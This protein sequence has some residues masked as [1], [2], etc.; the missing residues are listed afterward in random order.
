M[1]TLDY[2]CYYDFCCKEFNSKYNLKRHINSVHL[3]I[4]EYQCDI[5]AKTLVSKVAFKEHSY[6]H[7]R[8]KPISCPYA[9]CTFTFSRSSLLCSH[10]KIH[11]KEQIVQKKKKSY[12]KRKDFLILPLIEKQRS[13]RQLKSKISLHHLLIS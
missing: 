11:K 5:C 12:E 9:G 3:K 13:E 8:I 1:K 2:I 6:S 7:Q 4:R 10:K